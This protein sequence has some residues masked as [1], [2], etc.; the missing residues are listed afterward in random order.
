MVEVK[1]LLWELSLS[2]TQPN[3]TRFPLLFGYN[4]I[5]LYTVTTLFIALVVLECAGVLADGCC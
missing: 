5:V 4:R 2:P 3:T 1:G